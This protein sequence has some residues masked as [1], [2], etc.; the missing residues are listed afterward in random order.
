[1]LDTFDPYCLNTAFKLYECEPESSLF[2]NTNAD[3]NFMPYRH[4][5]VPPIQ[6]ITLYDVPTAVWVAQLAYYNILRGSAQ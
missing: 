4:D 6:N 5:V 2:R 1:M 3:C